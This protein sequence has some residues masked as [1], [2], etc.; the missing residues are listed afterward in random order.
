MC[1]QCWGVL[2]GSCR[3]EP[4]NLTS[5]FLSGFFCCHFR[6][7]NHAISPHPPRSAA[8]SDLKFHDAAVVWIDDNELHGTFHHS[9]KLGFESLSHWRDEQAGLT[10]PI[11]PR[12]SRR[13]DALSDCFAE[14]S[15]WACSC[16][17]EDQ[18][19]CRCEV[20]ANG[21]VWNDG[22]LWRRLQS[23]GFRF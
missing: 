1:N 15:D 18:H 8:M 5:V 12:R 3:T 9:F 6:F 16:C 11:S 13:L 14:G 21:L 7:P 19:A 10:T 2:A 17:G 22:R 20:D 23:K 4:D